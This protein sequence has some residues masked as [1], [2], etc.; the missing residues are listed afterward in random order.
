MISL[1]SFESYVVPRASEITE[2]PVVV[3]LETEDVA[4]VCWSVILAFFVLFVVSLDGL[5]EPVSSKETSFVLATRY[6]H[7]SC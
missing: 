3:T 5:S 7:D 4:F 2:L 1:I 6:N